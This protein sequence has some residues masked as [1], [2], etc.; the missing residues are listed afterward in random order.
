MGSQQATT[1]SILAPEYMVTTP[2]SVQ[3][4][5][6][7]PRDGFQAINTLIPTI[8]KIAIIRRLQAVGLQRI[9]I[10]AFVNRCVLPQMADTADVLAD[11]IAIPDFDPQVLV[12]TERY[13]KVAVDAGARH[14][15]FVLSAS[16]KHNMS[17]V[18]RT[19]LDSVDEYARIAR[20]LPD[21][22][23]LRLNIATAFDCPFD[24]PTAPESTLALL[25]RLTRLF[26]GAE[27]G[28]CDTTGRATP[29]RVKM[30]FDRAMDQFPAISGWAYH[31]HDTYGLGL[32]NVF[33]AWQAG[34]RVFDAAFAGLGGCP[35]APGATGNVATEDVAWMFEAM[36]VRTG[37]DVQ[38]LAG[39]AN[40]GAALPGALAG[41]RVRAALHRHEHAVR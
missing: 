11:V 22:G 19:P 31:G 25:E 16:E 40:T 30:L 37:V 34:V 5:E 8:D 1:C 14:L 18:R 27:V 24:G 38:T 32:V 28:L 3:I 6:V 21:G 2:L 12:P 15:V 26:P 23:S 39:I 13:A 41:G 33:A 4:V 35:F 9:E 29:D 7:G 36:G 20:L 17:N 10:G